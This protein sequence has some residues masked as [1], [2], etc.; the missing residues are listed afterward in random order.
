MYVDTLWVF[1]FRLN[2]K[3]ISRKQLEWSNEKGV[4]YFFVCSQGGSAH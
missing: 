3:L 2:V 4:F 1:Y